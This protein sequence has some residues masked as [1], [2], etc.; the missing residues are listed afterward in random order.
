MNIYRDWRP[1]KQKHVLIATVHIVF[2][3]AR[4][5]R[6]AHFDGEIF[7]KEIQFFIIDQHNELFDY[8]LFGW[9]IVGWSIADEKRLL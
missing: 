2:E 8:I 3:Q 9:V 5:N 7:V 6:Q 4:Q 1:G